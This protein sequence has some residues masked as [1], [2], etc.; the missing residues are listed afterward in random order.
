MVQHRQHLTDLFENGVVYERNALTEKISALCAQQWPANIKAQLETIDK[1]ELDTTELIKQSAACAR[2]QLQEMT[3][4]ESDNLKKQFILL[5]NELNTL[6]ENE[7]YFENDI[8]QL[9]NKF[10]QLKVDLERFPIEISVTKIPNELIFV[11]SIVQSASSSAPASC[12]VDK[13]LTSQKPKTS[14]DLSTIRPGRMH[15]FG[16]QSIAFFSDNAL[17]TLYTGQRS[18]QSLNPIRD[19]I[20]LHWSNCIQQFLVLTLS[21]RRNEP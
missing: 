20:E 17:S 7:N 19:I 12:F 16:E 6:R 5:S 2:K 21:N 13:L 11:K 8:D 3:L 15:P 4:K 14:I 9:T 18:W 1:W 10:Q